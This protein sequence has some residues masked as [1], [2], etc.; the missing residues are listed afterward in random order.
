V[1]ESRRRVGDSGDR[2]VVGEVLAAEDV[3]LAAG[4]VLSYAARMPSTTSETPTM[5]RP[6]GG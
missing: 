4:S 5:L 6:P 2:P 1:Q 3:V